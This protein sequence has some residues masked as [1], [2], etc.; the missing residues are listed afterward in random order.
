MPTL[1]PYPSKQAQ[2]NIHEQQ[3]K[4]WKKALDD[5]LRDKKLNA[6]TDLERITADG[7]IVEQAK[8]DIEK[9]RNIVKLVFLIS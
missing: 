6:H 5:R 4:T 9:T 2:D 7:L 8:R 3:T 1:E